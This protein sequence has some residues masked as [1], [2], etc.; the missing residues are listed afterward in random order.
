MSRD[1][2]D[3]LNRLEPFFEAPEP[4]FERFVRRRD[5][6]RRHQRIAAGVVGIA[7]FVAA[8]WIVTS[9]APGDRSLTPGSTGPTGAPDDPKG[10]GLVGVAP[11]GA[12]PSSPEHGELVLSFMFGHTAGDPGRFSVFVYADGRLIWQRLGDRSVGADEYANEYSTGFVEQRLTPEGVEL[13][14]AEV[15][16]TG[17]VG[18]DLHLSAVYG[19]KFGQ[20]K[21]RIGDRLVGVTWGDCCDPSSADEARTMPTPEQASALQRLDARL[22]DPVSWLPA[23]AWEDPEITA[24][25]PSGY[26]VCYEAQLGTGLSQALASLPQPAEDQLRT[27]ERTHEELDLQ[28]RGGVSLDI[29]CSHVP[30]EEARALAQ[31]LDDAGA[32]ER[33]EDVFGLRYVFGQRDSGATEVTLTIEALLPHVA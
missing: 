26:S 10:V 4:S 13:V 28:Y 9:G 21:V 8:V 25:V 27:L 32:Q 23:S 16:S 22:A 6:K 1:R 19:L 20:L 18:H 33:H 12:T 14:K 7:V 24:Y 31:T 3:V 5:R 2:F 17:L 29:W 15:I 11:E 30:T